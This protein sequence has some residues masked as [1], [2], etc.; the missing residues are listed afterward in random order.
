MDIPASVVVEDIGLMAAASSTL[1]LFLAIDPC[2]SFV[3]WALIQTSSLDWPSSATLYYVHL[4]GPFA[5]F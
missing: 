4:P 1:L 2:S 3:D 5:L